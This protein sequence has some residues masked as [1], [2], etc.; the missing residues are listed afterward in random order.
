MSFK[1]SRFL[2]H[3]VILFAASVVLASAVTAQITEQVIFNFTGYN[4]VEPLSPVTQD[5]SGRLFGTTITGGNR[6]S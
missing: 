6:F 3:T 2:R 1:R 4:G 5:S